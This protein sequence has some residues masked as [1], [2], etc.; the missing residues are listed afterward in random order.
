MKDMQ[1][2]CFS[3]NH[4]PKDGEDVCTSVC[5]RVLP[6]R[7]DLITITPSAPPS[8]FTE[9]RLRHSKESKSHKLRTRMK[10]QIPQVWFQKQSCLGFWSHLIIS[11]ANNSYS[12]ETKISMIRLTADLLGVGFHS[13]PASGRLLLFDGENYTVSLLLLCAVTTPAA[14]KLQTIASVPTQ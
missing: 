7:R 12:K 5:A 8:R 6:D 3:V 10:F 14:T 11:S 9:L 4:E 13:P 2:G 1:S